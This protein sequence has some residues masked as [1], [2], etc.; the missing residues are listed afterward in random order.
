M[1]APKVRL[2]ELVRR[3]MLARRNTIR[4]SA[5]GAAMKRAILAILGVVVVVVAVAIGRTILFGRLPPAL[6]PA[7]PIGVDARAVARHL[8]EA[9][10]F[11][12]ISYGGGAHEAEKDAALDQ[13][14]GWLAKTYPNFHRV[15]TREVIGKS[16]LFTW[17]GENPN[18]PPVLLMAHMDVVPV[19]P[20][21]E[22][23]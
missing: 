14:R 10:R 18:L 8:A 23:D 1:A 22:R 6:E 5:A 13:M 20:G 7:P 16:L 17:K 15:A 21:S 19:V 9:V 2:P 4:H 12:T 11:R 3:W